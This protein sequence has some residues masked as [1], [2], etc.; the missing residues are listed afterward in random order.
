MAL[1]YDYAGELSLVELLPAAARTASANGTGVDVSGYVGNIK[2]LLNIGTVTGTTPTLDVKIQ[3]SADNS[4]WAD[5]SGYT[6]A[7]KT[8]AGSDSLSVDK[9]AVRKYIRAVATIGG[10]TPSFPCAILAVAQS[11]RV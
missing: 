11:K 4:S 10:T 5:V 6:I 3:D 7:Q 2:V 1:S 9:R 8:A